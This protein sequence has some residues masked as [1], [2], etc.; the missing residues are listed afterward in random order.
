MDATHLHL[1][2][3]HFPI[4]GTLIGIVILAY[5]LV[6]K[7]IDI[8]KVALATFILMAL[9]AIPVFLTGE[10]AEE[11]V[12]RLPGISEQLIE[13]HEELAEKA[14]WL[15][16]FL[17]ILSVS[18]FF[19]IFK[20]LSFAKTITVITLIVSLG[21]FGVFAQVGNLGGQIRHTEISDASYNAQINNDN[22]KAKHDV[23]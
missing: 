13:N 8:Q 16:G 5:G 22:P 2:L 21:T 4:I 15:M 9:F 18:S 20:K 19:A 3:S 17:G 12:E 14:I 11:T 1:V 6:S 23:D 10:E 7:N